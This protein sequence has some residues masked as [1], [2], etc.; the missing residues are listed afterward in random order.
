MSDLYY[1]APA[2]RAATASGKAILTG[3]EAQH[4]TRVMRKKAGDEVAL[5]DGEGREFRAVIAEVA[6]GR[7]E[8]EILEVRDD[9]REP[10]LAVTAIVAL[11]KGDR[12]KWAVEKLVELGVRRFVP[13]ECERSDVKIDDG[14]RERLERQTLEASKQCGRLRLMSITPSVRFHELPAM[15]ELLAART[16]DAA[17]AL[18]PGAQTLGRRFEPFGLFDEFK[19]G[20]EVLRVVTHPLSDGDFGQV[21][22]QTLIRSLDGRVPRGVLILVGPAGGFSHAEVEEAVAGGW[23]PL[24]LGRQVYRVETAALVA[25]ALFLHLS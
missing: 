21:G 3:A 17:R 15:L 10:D 14:V 16:A 11:P 6:R 23:T 1:I 24:E 13:L 19:Q 25:S 2:D 5:F 9:D 7:V 22:F 18:S 8:L 20:D 12:Q 4:L